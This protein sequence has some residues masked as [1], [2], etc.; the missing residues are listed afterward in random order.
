[1]HYER[2][3]KLVLDGAGPHSALAVVPG[4]CGIK[5]LKAIYTGGTRLY[6]LS[7]EA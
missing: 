5:T 7:L 6:I 1:M 3:R 4:I 2:A